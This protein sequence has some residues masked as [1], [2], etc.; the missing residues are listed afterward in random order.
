MKI[1]YTTKNGLNP[2]VFL[3]TPLSFTHTAEYF[4][5]VMHFSAGE[6]QNISLRKYV[7][8]FHHIYDHIRHTLEIALFPNV[9]V[10]YEVKYIK[11]ISF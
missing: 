3:Q 5:L 6:Q 1:Q 10:I 8:I 11:D 7:V 9:H 4:E 2:V